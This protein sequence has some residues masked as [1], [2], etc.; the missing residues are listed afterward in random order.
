MTEN[1]T[2]LLQLGL[3]I[4]TIFTTTFA[5][6]EWIWGRFLFYGEHTMSWADF[7]DGLSFSLPFLLILT[8]H[9]FGHYF[10]ARY[11]QI[12]V[13]LPY[14]IPLWFG[15]MLVPSIGTMGAIIRIRESIVSRIKYF[16]VGVSGPI[17]GFV[18]ALGVLWYG[19]SHLPETEYI[20]EVHP[21]YELF[22]ADFEQKMEGVD[23]VILKTSLNPE[24]YNYVMYQD[25]IQIGNYNYKTD[26]T[27]LTG[28][29]IQ[30]GDNLMMMAA[31][32]MWAPDDRYIPT[33]K[34]IMHYPWLLAGFLALF[35]TAL[36]L[37][38]IGQ[39][40]GGHV[41]FGLL[42][43]VWH[44]RI[45]KAFFVGLVFYSGLGWITMDQ[46]MNDSSEEMFG[47]IIQVVIYLYLVYL[48]SFTLFENRND[49]W[50]FAAVMLG[51]QFLLSSFLGLEGYQGWLLFAVL[52]GRFIGIKHPPVM[53][54]TPLTT[55]RKILGWLAIV[56]FVLC[57]S[58]EPMIV[59]G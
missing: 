14:Y 37:L 50:L 42:G 52:L 46:V 21:E 25:V 43:P 32:S 54:N 23:T 33:G 3:L 49:R 28:T 47:F 22:G 15:F 48:S 45:S 9:E 38:P 41:T 5:G 53:D 13:S 57:F 16:D 40:D 35:F 56:I 30:F 31:R 51:A 19:F 18:V 55:E 44:D 11:H 8:C 20:Y 10:T 34:E 29:G 1:R 12:K 58:P 7:Q 36:N 6:A 24:R 39:L 26:T 2:R 59:T 17:A 27:V 4:L